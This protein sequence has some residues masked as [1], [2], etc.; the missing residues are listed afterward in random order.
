MSLFGFGVTILVLFIGLYYDN[1]ILGIIAIGLAFLT[2]ALSG[3]FGNKRVLL[4]DSQIKDKR[5]EP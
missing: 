4:R 1:L 2:S 5:M 3:H